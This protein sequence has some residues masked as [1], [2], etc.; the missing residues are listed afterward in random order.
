M[1][2]KYALLGLANQGLATNKYGFV[3]HTTRAFVRCVTDRPRQ[4]SHALI[5]ERSIVEAG[6]LL[7]VC[8]PVV[9]GKHDAQHVTR[10][11]RGFP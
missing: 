2:R 3:F 9:S 1:P 10:L 8:Q 11:E 5:G 7:G 6:V 4:R